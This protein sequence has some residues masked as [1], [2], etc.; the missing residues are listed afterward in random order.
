MNRA[1]L[2]GC[3]VA[4]G[5]IACFVTASCATTANDDLGTRDASSALPQT[6]GGLTD[7]AD[8][9][10]V[11]CESVDWCSVPAPMSSRWTFTSIWGTSKT[12]V[13]AVGS[14]GTIAHYDGQAWTAAQSEYR[15]TFYAV[16]GSGPN[17]IWAA[18]SLQLL[19]HS[20]GIS[21]GQ[22]TWTN[23]PLTTSSNAL[24]VD[25]GP[26]RV[27]AIWGSGPDDVRIGIDANPV[28]VRSPADSA[29]QYS[30]EVNQFLKSGGGDAGAFQWRA[31]PSRGDRILSI[32][33]SSATDVWMTLENTNEVTYES[34]V[35]LHGTPYTGHRPNPAA[36]QSGTCYGCLPNCSACSVLDDP[37]IWTPVDT[38]SQVALES[39]WGSSADD[40][41]AVGRSGTIRR[42][43]AGDARWEIV[44]SPT[45]ATLHRVWGSGPNDVWM[46]GDGGTI[47][48]FDGTTLAP[49]TALFPNEYRPT[50]RGVWGS[51][52][53]D[54]WIVG[55]A[56]VLHY[57]G[58]KKDAP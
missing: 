43:R 3:S 49:S 26:K 32:W 6:D 46:V 17:D 42:F 10:A 35:T 52:P 8:A 19:L 9:S 22:V 21:N 33:G 24:I 54:V 45:T 37:L 55:E 7:V 14:G 2:F 29:F 36:L 44:P 56:I 16:W 40:V 31:M 15:D 13:W 47:I 25:R 5:T 58:P 18:S 38:Q 39:V 23:V 48:H 30:G 20:T 53:D 57:T 12:D 11:S 28:T 1:W 4:L 27:F 50:L 41:W 34:G 51:G